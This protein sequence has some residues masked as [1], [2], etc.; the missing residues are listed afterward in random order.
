MKAGQPHSCHKIPLDFHFK[1]KEEAKDLFDHLLAQ[2]NTHIGKYRIISLPCCIHLFGKYD[3]LAALP[4]KDKLEIRFSLDK[5]L[6]N[7]RIKQ[8][9]PLSSKSYKICLDLTSKE[10]INPELLNWLGKSYN[11]KNY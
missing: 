2:I 11:L 3:F 5:E 1:N 4:K 8:S 6:K 10:E 9:F 7:V